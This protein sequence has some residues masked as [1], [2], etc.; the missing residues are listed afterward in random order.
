MKR[1]M[2]LL[3]LIVPLGAGLGCTGNGARDIAMLAVAGRFTGDGEIRTSG[4]PFG[5]G[6]D[7]NIYM[8]SETVANFNGK[9]NFDHGETPPDWLLEMLKGP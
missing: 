7:T 2:L 8:G 6:Q 3:T 1:L 5:V 9:W 4:K